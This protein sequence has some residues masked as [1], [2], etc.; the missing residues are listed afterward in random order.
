M[1]LETDKSRDVYT[2]N[3][4]VST[5][6]YNF[7]IFTDDH[8]K[9]FVRDLDLNESQL[10]LDTDFTVDG[11]GNE[12]GGNINLIDNGQDWLE[13]TNGNLKQDYLLIIRRILPITQETD[14][15]NQGSFLPESHEDAL[16]VRTMV[17]QQLNEDLSRSVKL[18]E[19]IT[20]GD[21]DPTLPGEIVKPGQVFITNEEGDGFAEGPTAN[22]IQNAQGYAVNALNSRNTARDWAVLEDATVVDSETGADSGEYSSKEYAVGDARRGQVGG[23]SAKDW[24]E[25]LG[26]TVDDTGRS[27][28]HWANES[29]ESAQGVGTL[30]QPGGG[31]S[32]EWARNTTSTVDG[33]DYS[34]KEYAQ[35][36]QTRGQ[37]GGGSAKD[38]ANY[39]GGTVDDNEFSSKY[40]ADQAAQSATDSATNA[41]ASN[42]NNVEYLSFSDSPYTV[43]ELQ[44]GTLFSVDATGGNFVFNLPEISTLDLT[45]PVN[46]SF[47]KSDDSENTIAVN[48]S[49]SDTVTEAGITQALVLRQKQGVHLIPDIDLSPDRWAVINYGPSE[50]AE[51]TDFLTSNL[52]LNGDMGAFQRYPVSDNNTT[53]S[54]LAPF[55]YIGPDRWASGKVGPPDG[56]VRQTRFLEGGR[57]WFRITNNPGSITL[58]NPGNYIRLMEQRIEKRVTS[59]Y[60]TRKKEMALWFLVKGTNTGSFRGHIYNNNLSVSGGQVYCFPYDILQ[61]DVVELKKIVFPWPTLGTVNNPRWSMG[62][63]FFT[64]GATDIA[65]GTLNSWETRGTTLVAPGGDSHF[66]LPGSY[67]QFSEV[68]LTEHNP[69]DATPFRYQSGSQLSEFK[70]LHSYYCNSWQPGTGPTSAA[71]SFHF[72]RYGANSFTSL[73]DFTFS[74]PETMAAQPTMTFYSETGLSGNLTIE[75]FDRPAGASRLNRKGFS[76]KLT[77]PGDE[78]VRRD[79]AFPTISGH[80]EADAEI[81]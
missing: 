70:D 13:S 52:L 49:G 35:G 1:S 51:P 27:S 25:H 81:Y 15:R 8:I 58:S 29:Q 23:G 44:A 75:G 57:F 6:S 80:W 31:S 77:A 41:A 76:T 72:T 37:A 9:V 43:Q 69:L 16:D 4:S 19:S 62:V 24:A 63:G 2:G 64:S 78:N 7:K 42:W 30:G 79:S 54:I 66:G 40:W 73:T 17:D 21:F 68:Y 12:N 38:W 65:N 60:E 28:K 36:V 61:S 55:D 53:Q 50:D 10:I 26:G 59:L 48:S 11:I 39:M 5:Y 45:V 22:E 74:F 3:N 14:F 18:P 47:T 71:E 20:S 34:S 67:V 56:I 46:F 32:R 33:T